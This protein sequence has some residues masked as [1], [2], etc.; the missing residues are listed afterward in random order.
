LQ[1]VA[2]C[3]SVLQC[4]AVCCS[5]LQ[6]VAV[7]YSAAPDKSMYT[8]PQKSARRPCYI[9]HSQVEELQN[10]F[11]SDRRIKVHKYPAPQKSA[12][13]PFHMV[14]QNLYATKYCIQ[15]SRSQLGGCFA[16]CRE[17]TFQNSRLEAAEQ[18]TNVLFTT[19]R[20]P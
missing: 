17:L 14:N 10:T 16:W 11:S 2:V 12:R 20:M 19:C 1:C 3:C 7:C 5:V 18:M 13:R 9:V 8:M 15:F 4:V 6:C